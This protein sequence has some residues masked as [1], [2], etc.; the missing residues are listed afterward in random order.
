M[1]GDRSDDELARTATAPG[2]TSEP[3]TA[4]T[5]LE[6]GTTLARY[7]L[8]RA[9]GEGGMGMVYAAFDPDLE[10]R[11]AVKVLRTTED[12]GDEARQRLLR[13]ARAMARLTHPNVVTVHEVGTASG[14]D[15]VAMELIEGE[16]LAEWLRAAKRSPEEVL[17]TF[18]LA[19]RGLAAAHAAGLVHRD[20]KPHNVL[21]QRDG[22]I[23]VTDFGLARGVEVAAA[24]EAT[25]KLG[26]S[27]ASDRTPS[28]L[29][30]L[31]VTGSVLG[32]PAYM[33]PEQW[34]GGTVGPAADQ[35]AFCVALWEALAGE[36][37][38][39]GA[40][41]EDL[42]AEVQRGPAAVDDS[43]LPRRVRAVL[44]RGLDPDPAKR[45]PSMDALLHALARRDRRRFF[46]LTAAS[47]GVVAAAIAFVALRGGRTV[48]ACEPPARAVDDV[49]SPEMAAVL[50]A[51]GRGEVRDAI[52]K[53]VASW[54][55]QR[56][57]AC[58]A[59][60][61]QRPA[62]LACLDG[63]LARID[64][65]HHALEHVQGEVPGDG[66]LAYLV[67]PKVCAAPVPPRLTLAAKPDTI[68]AF[69]LAIDSARGRDFHRK[70][71][72]PDAASA[73][74]DKPGLDPCARGYARLAESA[75][76]KDVPRDRAAI[77][78]ALTAAELCGDDRLRAEVLL[79][80]AP[81]EYEVPVVGLRGRA[82]LEKAKAAVDRVAQDDLV[83]AVDSE[84]SGIFAGQH[85]WKEAFAAAKR[86]I[87]GFGARGRVRAQIG[88]VMTENQVRASRGEVADLTEMVQVVEKWKSVARAHH[89]EHALTGL[90]YSEAYAMMFLGDVDGAHAA[91]TNLYHPEPQPAD[92]TQRVEGS[93]V[94]QAGH[95]IAGARVAAASRVFLDS[96]GPS[97][98]GETQGALRMVTS[99]K[100]GKFVIPD[101][102]KRGGVAAQLLFRRG[103]SD[104][105]PHV[106][107]VLHETREVSGKVE[108]GKLPRTKV[109]VMVVPKGDQAHN[110][111]T[112][113]S[114][115][116]PDGTFRLLAVPKDDVSVGVTTWGA[117]FSAG[118]EYH[119]IPAG[120]DVRNLVLPVP[121]GNGRALDVIA[122]SAAAIPFDAAQVIIVPGKHRFQSVAEVYKELHADPHGQ[123]MTHY[124]EPLVGEAIP[125]DARPLVRRGDLIYHADDARAGDL[126]VCVIG[127][128]LDVA[129]TA[130][131]RKIQAH[132]TELLVKCEL[133][134]PDDK[135]IVVEAPP[136][137]RFE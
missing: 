86:A 19:G 9:L 119:P 24:L 59:G 15:Y 28:S 137:K 81:L 54:R 21:R 103:Y 63:V 115:L 68:D 34:S 128:N 47:C 1:P 20:F 27:A 78:D 26:K 35:F 107:I 82:A 62:R 52:D 25:L 108:L 87:D 100:D 106:T 135:A 133:A 111:I 117:D 61:D 110:A 40:T 12:A 36:R 91:L 30:G 120:G 118:L 49:W 37:P 114:P 74:A 46:A 31:T 41:F 5:P 102:P 94:D 45:W 66:V 3:A 44:R 72:N 130:Y 17:T 38:F 98:F 18:L 2:S 97:P 122:R 77:G 136:Q 70:R 22:R 73:L 95:P 104:L 132:D 23:C 116:A 48:P 126:T 80:E 131:W 88:A 75:M 113:M 129:D 96:V 7:R 112:L 93:V 57:Q 43:K 60:P 124:A 32:T 53:D 56:E 51:A 11:V 92:A 55:G 69:A 83:A 64:A 134:G 90:E 127:L 4:A 125:P 6:L 105:V 109:F 39:G 89:L 84:L 58:T 33:A 16:T 99:D 65:L 67:D 85:H 101:A 29:S 14:R 10:R 71:W 76:T 42:K 79:E 50:A 121:G 8:E 13:E 123:T